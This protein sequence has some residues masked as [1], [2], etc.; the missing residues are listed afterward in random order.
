MQ[1]TIEIIKERYLSGENLKYLFF[2]GHQPDISGKVGKSCFSQWWQCSFIIDGISYNC[3]EQYMMAEKA[4]LFGDTEIRDK[5]LACDHPKQAKDWGRQVRE[6]K[7]DI[8][9]KNCYNIVKKGN[10]EKFKQ[11]SDLMNFLLLT[12]NRI[13][14]EASP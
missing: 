13:L 9:K 5:I 8:W 12:K 6:F 2:W 10:Y 11:N 4:C 3:A 7:E 14:V 1:Y